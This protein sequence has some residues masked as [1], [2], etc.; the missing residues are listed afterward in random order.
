MFLKHIV[1]SIG[2]RLPVQY[3]SYKVEFALRGAAHI[4]GVL[5]VNWDEISVLERKEVEM[6]E[7][8]LKRIKNEDKMT[9]DEKQGLANFADMFISCTLKE[10]RTK[11]IVSKVNVHHHTK[12]C[13]KFNTNCRFSFPKFPALKTIVSVPVRIAEEDPEK[14]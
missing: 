2:S 8:A 11:K 4:H 1:M 10:K 3:Y 14:R 5:W 9:T 13:R 12:A 7:V 6:I